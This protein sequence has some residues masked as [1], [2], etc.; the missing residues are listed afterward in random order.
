VNDG[1]NG[2]LIVRS[3]Q[4]GGFSSGSGYYFEHYDSNMKLIKEYEYERIQK[5]RY[6]N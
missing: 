5:N 4:G 3:Y 1:N 2:T 6:K